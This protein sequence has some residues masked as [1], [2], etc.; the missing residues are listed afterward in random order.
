MRALF[1]NENIG[2]HG[3]LHMHLR[4]AIEAH[5]PDVHARFIDIPEKGF[6]RRLLSA[7]VPP[8]DRLDLDLQQIRF[9]LAQSEVARRAVRRET[10]TPDVVHYY[11]QNVALTSIGEMRATPSV[12]STDAPNELV[13]KMLPYRRPT[14]FTPRI[15]SVTSRIE[16][17]AY[18]AAAAVV[19]HSR[20]ASDAIQDLHGVPDEKL[21]LIPFGILLPP[22]LVRDPAPRRPRLLFVGRSLERKGGTGLLELW[23]RRF[24]DDC[25]LTLVTHDRVAPEPGL[26]VLNDVSPGDDRLWALLAAADVFVFPSEIDTFG[27]AVVEALAAGVPTVVMDTAAVPE[28]APDGEVGFVVPVGD[29][30][31]V[32]DAIERLLGDEGL[33]RRLGEAGRRRAEERFDARRTTAQLLE[34]LRS[35][36]GAV[37]AP[38]PEASGA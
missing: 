2:G 10:V 3:T 1:V 24:R 13:A 5:H 17:R 33:R 8:L 7:R 20:W 36:T 37:A 9:Q 21:H 11:T 12:L 14:R 29:F 25:V 22:P 19:S 15:S 23:R 28:V 16:G 32:G 6:G 38:S 30:S 27:Y 34:V 35:V 31:A 4:Q 26:E 18:R